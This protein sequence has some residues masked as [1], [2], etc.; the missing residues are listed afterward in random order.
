M[1]IGW[2][3]HQQVEE[4]V[5]TALDISKTPADMSSRFCVNQN[6]LFQSKPDI[7]LPN[8]PE[9]NQSISTALQDI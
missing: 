1:I 3:S 4:M 2:L 7:S 5:L 9:P 6:W 8:R